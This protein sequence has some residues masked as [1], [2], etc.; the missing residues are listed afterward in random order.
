MIVESKQITIEPL[1]PVF[2][3]SGKTLLPDF[4]FIVDGDNVVIIDFDKLIKEAKS[5]EELKQYKKFLK[6]LHGI[7]LEFKIARG[8]TIDK[9]LDINPYIIP[10]SEVKG[11]IRTAVINQ[12][13]KSDRKAFDEYMTRILNEM[14][15]DNLKSIGQ[16]VEQVIKG[17]LPIKTRYVYD[18][19]KTLLISDPIVQ[20]SEFDLN[21]IKV[22]NIEGELLG[23]N[24]AI[25]FTKGKLIYDAK[26]IKPKDYGV[27]TSSDVY[28]L[29]SK[30]TWDLIVNSLRNFS[31]VVIADEKSKINKYL[32]NSY[33][34]QKEDLNKYLE[35]IKNIENIKDCIPLRIGMFTGHVSKT[36][37]VRDD[38]KRKRETLLTISYGKRWD[39]STIK[40]AGGVGLGW[41]KMCIK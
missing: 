4:D 8:K 41:I 37:E 20:S 18:A 26:I 13:I 9:I 35:L 16:I 36:I 19:L 29:T 33:G 3:W 21:E 38:V 15:E 2:V 11:L 1:S 12:L 10:A 39:N 22:L 5:E 40:I 31:K 34:H 25:T 23:S 30:V 17:K 7:K 6:E 14:K 32:S 28:N 27:Y 24:Y